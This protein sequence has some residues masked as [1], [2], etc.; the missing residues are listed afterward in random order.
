MNRDELAKAAGLRTFDT[1]LPQDWVDRVFLL[2]GQWPQDT[3]IVW[4]Y[5]GAGVFGS[6]HALTEEARALLDRLP[7][8]ML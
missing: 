1:A 4:C 3:D 5:D 2:T 7:K 8:E 6:P